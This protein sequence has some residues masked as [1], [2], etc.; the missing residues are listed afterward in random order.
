MT[1]C[2]SGCRP[3]PNVHLTPQCNTACYYSL[4]VKYFSLVNIPS[5]SLGHMGM[6][7]AEE[8]IQNS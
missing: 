1:T 8:L 2:C 3:S 6:V 5:R 7:K 4:S